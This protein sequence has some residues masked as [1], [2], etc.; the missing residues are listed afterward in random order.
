M[1]RAQTIA[2]LIGALAFSGVVCV[3]LFPATNA[4][5]RKPRAPKAIMV[6]PPEPPTPTNPPATNRFVVPPPKPFTN[7]IYFH[8]APGLKGSNYIW[9]VRARRLGA[10]N[11]SVIWLN[12]QLDSG[13]FITV[14]NNFPDM[15]FE[16]FA[17]PRR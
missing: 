1:R 7:D 2:V 4:V 11:W 12:A 8:Y 17:S 6:L 5:P 15:E 14:T 9:G 13:G 3:S 16:P 10:S